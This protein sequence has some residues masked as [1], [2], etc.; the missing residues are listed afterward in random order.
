MPGPSTAEPVVKLCRKPMSPVLSAER[1]SVSGTS[2]PRWTRI[3]YG[4]LACSETAAGFVSAC[5]LLS[6]E[7]PVDDIHL[8]LAGQPHEIDSITGHADRQA[9][10]LFR[11]VHGLEQ[12]LAVEHVDVHV[13]AGDPEKAVED[14]GEI[15][16]PVLFDP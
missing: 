3:S 11:M 2:S 4:D 8:L 6:V 16:D 12:G 1:T 9:R 13:E 10:I 14:R 15:G 5:I 7:C